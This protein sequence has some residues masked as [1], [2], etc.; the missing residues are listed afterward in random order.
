MLDFFCHFGENILTW[1][2][3][4]NPNAAA[5]TQPVT[6]LSIN[7]DVSV[8]IEVTL[9]IV[10]AS[11]TTWQK[12]DEVSYLFIPLQFWWGNDFWEVSVSLYLLLIGRG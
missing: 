1:F 4:L 10:D 11:R 9:I 7:I 2:I 3:A 12:F 6:N 5:S 8:A